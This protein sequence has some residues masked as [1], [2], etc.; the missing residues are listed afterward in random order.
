[1]DTAASRVLGLDKSDLPALALLLFGG[2]LP[3]E[4]LVESLDEEPARLRAT[5]GRLERAGYVHDAEPGEPLRLTPHAERWIATL[6]TPLHDE[7]VKLCDRYSVDQLANVSDFL[8]AACRIQERN[9]QRV[10]QLLRTPPV[11]ATGPRSGLSRAALRRVQVFV[12]SNLSSEI[13]LPDMAARAE[14]SEFHFARAFKVSVDTTP[15]AY[16]ESRRIAAAER[17]IGQTDL[18]LAQIA[19]DVGLGSQ[20][21]LTTAFRRATGLTPAHYRRKMAAHAQ[22]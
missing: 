12:E 17:L 1:M 10:A 9:A 2:P 8:D 5:L 21:R 7:G 18:P 4:A 13:R 3:A 14:L 19:F 15:R 22:R 6:W 20:S 11:K 16:V